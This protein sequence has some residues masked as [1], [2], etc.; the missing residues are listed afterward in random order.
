M[1]VR[2][3]EWRARYE[4]DRLTLSFVGDADRRAVA[5]SDMDEGI[6]M[7]TDDAGRI[8]AVSIA[9]AIRIVHR[10]VRPHS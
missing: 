7:H 1:C 2:P 5:A 4:S 3:L 9:D 6:T 10:R 8:V